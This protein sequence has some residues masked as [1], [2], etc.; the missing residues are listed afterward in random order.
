MPCKI[1]KLILQGISIFWLITITRGCYFN[2]RFPD[3]T[4]KRTVQGF[5][6][7]NHGVWWAWFCCSFLPSFRSIDW[8]RL[9]DASLP[10]GSGS[11]SRSSPEARKDETDND[12]TNRS[13]DVSPRSKN[14]AGG[15][16]RP[17]R[18]GWDGNDT[19]HVSHPGRHVR[20]PS[21]SPV[22]S[23]WRQNG[24]F[25]LC[26]GVQLWCPF[27]LANSSMRTSV[28]CFTVF[29]EAYR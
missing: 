28:V 26:L 27:L 8:T 1:S 13:V 19:A 18:T 21:P 10:L 20:R 5:D 9:F 24:C 7:H 23:H 3:T 16:G 29:T 4:L 2:D 15:K 25:R 17:W 14:D 6:S 11:I 22:Q 12:P